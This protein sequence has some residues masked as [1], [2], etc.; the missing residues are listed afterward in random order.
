MDLALQAKLLR[1]LQERE[2]ERLGGRKVIPLDVRILATTNRD[3]YQI[4]A[5][6]K[7]REDLFYRLNV[8]PLNILPL[9][10]RANDILPLVDKMLNTYSADR[11]SV[12]FSESAKR[13][14]KTH[15]WPGNV[16][17][18]DNVIQRALILKAGNI[19]ESNDIQFEDKTRYVQ[20]VTETAN[21]NNECGIRF[22]W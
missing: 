22:K 19:I 9:R 6:G 20:L 2:V 14:L 15:F 8:F 18:L 16:R 21:Q 11:D 4:V 13:L 12:Y 17:E 5:E 10:E 3:I 1:V 7:F